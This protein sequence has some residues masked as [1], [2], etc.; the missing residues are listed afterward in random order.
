MDKDIRN[1]FGKK[2][3]NNSN[4]NTV[5]EKAKSAPMNETQTGKQ[6]PN[7][8]RKEEKTKKKRKAVEVDKIDQEDKMAG[9]PLENIAEK[10]S[11]NEDYVSKQK[12]TKGKSNTKEKNDIKSI[13]NNQ[14]IKTIKTIENPLPPVQEISNRKTQNKKI[15]DDDMEVEGPPSKPIENGTN[16]AQIT[17]HK[18]QGIKLENT[19]QNKSINK[20]NQ[21]PLKQKV[22]PSVFFS[23]GNKVTTGTASTTN[24]LSKEEPNS[25]IISSSNTNNNDSLKDISAKDKEKHHEKKDI[26]VVEEEKSLCKENFDHLIDDL[27][28]ESLAQEMFVESTEDKKPLTYNI[29]EKV[30]SDS[31]FNNRTVVQI[32]PN[33]NSS[34]IKNDLDASEKEKNSF[35]RILNDDEKSNKSSSSN[36]S[37]KNFNFNFSS[38]NKSNLINSKSLQNQSKLK[39]ENPSSNKVMINNT[40]SSSENTTNQ[41]WT[42]KY[43]PQDLNSIIGNHGV[44]QKLKKWLEDWDDVH[45]RGIKRE[46]EFSHST[47][48]KSKIENINAKACIISGSPGIGKTSAV[49]ILANHLGFKKFELNASDQRNKQIIMS[50]V[51]YLMDNTTI[52]ASNISQKNLIIMDEVDGMGGTEDKGG[53]SALIEIVK[54]TKVPI[55]CICNDIWNRKL[56]SLVNHCYDLKFSKPE[57]PQVLKRLREICEKEKL[58]MEPAS[59]ENLYENSGGDIRQ[60]LNFLEMQ[61]RKMRC[62]SSNKSFDFKESLKKGYKDNNLML[63]AFEACKRLLNKNEVRNLS[64]RARLDL[65][66][67]DFDLIPNLIHENYL[68]AFGSGKS[69]TDI[70]RLVKC[71]DNISLGDIIDKKIHTNNEWNLLPNKGIC[72]SVAPGFFTNGFIYATKFPEISSKFSKV[73]K[74]M[75][76]TK[77][78]K[79]LFPYNSLRTIKDEIVPILFSR[80][81]NLLI[82]YGKDA[83]DKVMNILHEYKFNMLLFKENLFEL[84][85]QKLLAKYEKMNSTIK[86]HLTKKLNE[87]YKTSLIKKKKKD[88]GK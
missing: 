80:I 73:R 17:E 14:T 6:N 84:V 37:N 44:V 55:I 41:L 64:H 49:R 4:I 40:N 61:S 48:G 78:L 70:K 28:L 12:K 39:K 8:P 59:L 43:N 76:Q 81:V 38:T 75:R 66:F 25:N 24:H 9:K 65:F 30:N 74:V 69:L 11:L 21:K 82:E 87:E 77:E 23:S 5:Q 79:T 31:I 32:Q 16:I 7:A 26:T 20:S 86:T 52:S 46:V 53:I 72:S 27:D 60:C 62:L 34:L 83:V 88:N 18:N 33:L 10:Q 47:R 85:N 67:I 42:S 22:D 2:N 71:A 57:K 3:S 19:V 15:I 29:C 13:E 1:F 36:Y 51:G 58:Y 54:K 68:S 45:L 56:R 50:K 63:N 35:K